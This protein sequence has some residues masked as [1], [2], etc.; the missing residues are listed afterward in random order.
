MVAVREISWEEASVPGFETI[1]RQAWREAVADI[2][3]KARIKLPECAGRVDSAVR[4]VLA[5]DAELLPDGMVQV[6]SQS[7]GTAAYLVGNGECSCKDFAK[8]PHGLCKHRL[9]AAITRRAQE[10]IKA[11]RAD[12]NGQAE[13]PSQPTPALLPEAPASVNVHLDFAGRQV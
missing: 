10:L 9:A 2:A 13:A 5:G 11:K 7:N 12:T 3:E 8:A 6:A 4:I 1:T